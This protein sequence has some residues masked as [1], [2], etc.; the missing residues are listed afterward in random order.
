MTSN[1]AGPTRASFRRRRS[2]TC[3]ES[4]GSFRALG[5][6]DLSAPVDLLRKHHD[7]GDPVAVLTALLLLTDRSCFGRRARLVASVVGC[8]ALDGS[9]LDE[10]AEH[11][12]HAEE[13]VVDI[14]RAWIEERFSIEIEVPVGEGA[15]ES[16]GEFTPDPP[17][18]EA[19]PSFVRSR[20]RFD[21][22][23]RL[24]AAQHLVR[25]DATRVREILADATPLPPDHR[26][27]I[28]AGV[29]RGAID[30]E[31]EGRLSDDA[32]RMAVDAGLRS[33]RGAFRLEAL[34]LLARRAPDEARARAASDPDAKVRRWAQRS[35][36]DAER[37]GTFPG[38][39]PLP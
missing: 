1:G 12:V 29:V 2:R 33:S 8:E 23:S 15:R 31:D 32:F 3:T 16:G 7:R 27:A 24:W 21:P 36:A 10:I 38:I 13:L 37:P 28:G 25:R 17:G 39:S 5:Y 9:C 20:R 26:A 14:P 4:S 22:P 6:D 11:V 35:G 18:D 34:E 30:L 19:V